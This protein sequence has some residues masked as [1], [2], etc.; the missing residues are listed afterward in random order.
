MGTTQ[1]QQL[2]GDDLDSLLQRSGVARVIHLCT[3]A[4]DGV[5]ATELPVPSAIADLLREYNHLFDEPRGLPPRRAFDHTIP[6]LPG[7]KPV[8]VW[9]YRYNPAQKDEVE[10]QVADMLALGII[11]P[12]SS[13]F[14]SPVLLVQKKDLTWC[15]CVDYRHLNMVTVKNRYPLLVIDELLDEL[16][17]AKFFTSLDLRSGYHQIR[18]KP[19]DAHKTAFKTHNSH[20]EF[21]VLSYGL[22][23]GLATFQG[24][25]NIVLAPL[26]RHDVLVFIDDILVYSATMEKHVQLLWQVFQ[27]LDEHQLKIKLSKCSFAC[28]SLTYL[29][30]DIS[31][32]GVRTDGR[33]ITAVQKWP[34]PTN[35]KEVRGFLGL[36]GYYRK[37]VKDFGIISRPLTDLTW[38]PTPSESSRRHW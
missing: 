2:S 13:P 34:T 5:H 33:N 16:A 14:A 19:E 17:G 8:N 38:K 1:C 32:E 36:A 21:R 29:A 10:C 26:N 20:Y 6:L 11:V 15:F 35:V 4:D 3:V 12:S 25:M 9:P 23:G 31:S 22:T 18:M 27:L 24:G 30:H 28:L 7:A 37:F